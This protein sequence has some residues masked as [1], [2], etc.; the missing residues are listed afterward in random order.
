MDIKCDINDRTLIVRVVGEIDHH[1]SAIIKD[2]VERIFSK[3]NCKYIV[4]DFSGV[5]FMDSS[6]IG[7]LIG[8][9]KQAENIGGSLIAC[10]ISPELGRIFEIS[11]L[12]K[13]IKTYLCLEEA[14]TYLRREAI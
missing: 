14:L 6:G 11:G 10:S 4:F 3:S 1:S 8:R 7:M 5:S 2:R 13:I 9:F 12:Y